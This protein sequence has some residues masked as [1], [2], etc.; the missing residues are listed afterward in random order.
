[1]GRPSRSGWVAFVVGSVALLAACTPTG[2]GPT[3]TVSPQGPEVVD[4]AVGHD[5]SCAVLEDGRVFCWGVNENGELG[6]GTLEDSPTPVLVEGLGP[7]RSVEVSGESS[8]IQGRSTCAVLDDGTVACWGSGGHGQLGTGT[9][10]D[11]STPQQVQGL[12]GV[13]QVAVGDTHAC[14]L[15]DDGTVRCWGANRLYGQVGVGPGEYF[16]TPQQVPGVSGAVSVAAGYYNTCVVLADGGLQCWGINTSGQIGLPASTSV[17]TPR[18]LDVAAPVVAVDAEGGTVCAAHGAQGATCWGSAQR[19]TLY[20]FPFGGGML[21][22][23]TRDD[24]YLPVWVEGVGSPTAVQLGSV[25]CTYAEGQVPHCW[26]G[27]WSTTD[28]IIGVDTSEGDGLVLPTPLH[29]VGPVVDL[30]VGEHHACAVSPDGLLS[31]WGYNDRG[32]LGDGSG[33]HVGLADGTP[34]RVQFPM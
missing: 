21:G 12:E 23:G 8:A 1:M 30:G 18:Q 5:H 24:S 26:G 3:T 22:D 16:N 11:A 32:Q 20:G 4:V 34:V 7:A 10:D 31:C 33:L 2:P 13:V 15:L 28:M 9:Y 6:D 27:K 14:A 25:G 19:R 17:R 29:A